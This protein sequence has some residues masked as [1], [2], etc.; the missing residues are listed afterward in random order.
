[1]SWKKEIVEK[2]RQGAASELFLIIVRYEGKVIDYF[3][4][5]VPNE[6]PSTEID[7]SPLLTI[8]SPK[9]VAISQTDERGEGYINQEEKKLTLL[10]PG[11]LSYE[12]F[13]GDDQCD[14]AVKTGRIFYKTYHRLAQALERETST[15]LLELANKQIE[16]EKRKNQIVA[17]RDLFLPAFKAGTILDH[18]NP[19]IDALIKEINSMLTEGSH[20]T[21]L[22]SE[23]WKNRKKKKQV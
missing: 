3:L 12:L 9:W 22:F 18:P 17:I 13:V 20:L 8:F 10:P 6:K 21:Q 23:F 1:M 14:Q 19:A 5:I 2:F 11:K 16:F 7:N 4:G 15:P